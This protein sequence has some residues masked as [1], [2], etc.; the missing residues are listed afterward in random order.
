MTIDEAIE[1]V[2]AVLER[3]RLSKVQE[4]VFRQS[5]EGLSYLEIAKNSGYDTGYLKDAG[6]GLWRSL[7]QAFGDKVTKNNFTLVLKRHAQTAVYT[8]NSVNSNGKYNSTCERQNY[9]QDTYCD[10]GS[11][12][13]TGIFY[14]RTAE[15]ATLDQWIVSDRARLVM[16]LGMGG[17]GKTTLSIKLAEKIQ[18][19][20]TYVIWRS[21]R[22]A[23]TI[24]DILTDLLN[25]LSTGQATNLPEGID[26]K[27]SLLISYLRA[28]RCLVILDNAETILRSGDRA[29]SYCQGYEGYG[30]LL[31][32]VAETT[33]Q[34]CLVLT[35]R[36]KPRGLT[37]NEGL[38]LPV[39][40][41]YLLGLTAVAAQY[42]FQ[43]KG[44][45]ISEAQGKV[46]I[47]RYGGNPLALKIIATNIQELFDGNVCQFI[48]QGTALFGD[49][50]N[51]LDQHF[52]RLSDLEK[53]IMY[54][55]AISKEW[56]SIP[57]LLKD[58]VLVSPREFLEALESLRA[59]SLIEK[60]TPTTPE[61]TS[62]CFVQQPAVMEYVTNKLLEQKCKENTHEA[63]NYKYDFRIADI[64]GLAAYS[65]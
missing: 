33:H 62:H 34:S 54:A 23:P 50:W 40:S 27:I 51:L 58:T 9:P 36:E 42:I 5:W 18:E 47:E 1:I 12:A 52:E 57:E 11:A 39:R 3:G 19:K 24:Q 32:C 53:D 6:C 31:R 61:E 21:L 49:I 43:A 63:A 25:H 55:L 2:E 26:G 46:L 59:R 15:L 48:T 14:G 17:I 22:N 7:S 60:A 44:L 56:V 16:L 10:W 38:T 41:L 65:P 13:D 29:G 30:Q 37:S 28:S 35:S 8:T 64:S 20:F 45:L 4:I